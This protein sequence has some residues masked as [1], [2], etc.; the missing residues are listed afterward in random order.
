MPIT[1]RI[2]VAVSPRPVSSYNIVDWDIAAPLTGSVML[3]RSTASM[4]E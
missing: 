1:G 3:G 4:N 2:P